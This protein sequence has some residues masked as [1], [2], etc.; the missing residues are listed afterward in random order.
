MNTGIILARL[1][2]IHNGHIELIKKA[3]N[4]N[5]QVYVFVGSADKF[6]KRNPIPISTRLE[7]TKKA[8]IES[9][10][11]NDDLN[12]MKEVEDRLLYLKIHVVPLDD[13]DDESN[14]SHE[15]GFYLY[16]KIVTET[17]EPNFTIYYSDGF[18]IITTWFPGF[19]L[20]NNVSLSLLARNS[21]ENG[22]SATSVRKMIM[23][24]DDEHLKKVVPNCVFERRE[25][26][27]TLIELSEKIH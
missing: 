9:F 20:R 5:D 24:G 3:H 16:S 19:I 2:P 27:K 15:W 26:L 18:E 25:H 22:I 1:Q 10:N 4:E 13:L 17:H 12:D 23:E 8:I 6:N 11:F 21:V 14:N 7:L